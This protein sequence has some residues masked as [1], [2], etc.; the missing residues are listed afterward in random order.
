MIRRSVTVDRLCYP[1]AVSDKAVSDVQR[2]IG[3]LPGSFDPL[4]LGHLDIF[5]RGLDLFDHVIVAILHNDAKTPL[6]A[7]E[8]RI[9]MIHASVSERE[10]ERVSVEVFDG[11]LVD[12]AESRGASV[13]LRGIRAVSDFEYEYQM[14]LMNRKLNPRIQTVFMMPKDA[15][16]Y[17]SSRLVKEVAALGGDLSGVVPPMVEERLRKRFAARST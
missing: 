16:S 8:E 4:T 9:E 12:F 13:I 14:A 6:F 17:V 7:L 1:R 3:V 5:S 2:R 15:Y 10:R 11:L